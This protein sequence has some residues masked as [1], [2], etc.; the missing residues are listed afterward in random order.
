MGKHIIA[1][2]SFCLIMSLSA[3]EYPLYRLP[4]VPQLDGIDDDEIWLYIPE[5]RGFYKIYG[6][7]AYATERL[8]SFK[9]GWN[10]DGLYIYVLR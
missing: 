1:V 10:S 4:E 7:I 9:M 6:G 3:L 5:G 8:T 2:L